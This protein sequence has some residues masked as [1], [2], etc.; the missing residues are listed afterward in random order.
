MKPTTIF[1]ASAML[2]FSAGAPVS[3][4]G[5]DSTNHSSMGGMKMSAADMDKMMSCRRMSKTEMMN[6]KGCSDAMKMHP[7]MMKMTHAEM[8]K[9]SA[10]MGM[11]K[12]VMMAD[13]SCA[14]M[15]E[16]HRNSSGAM[17]RTGMMGKR[18]GGANASAPPMMGA[19]ENTALMM[20]KYPPCTR[21][22]I[23]SCTQTNERGM[24]ANG[25]RH[26]KH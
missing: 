26:T 1:L 10:C 25:A 4:Q 19:N 17:N 6:D 24:R 14:S 8:E 23:D 13:K 21:E 5:H 22:R 3:A 15:M 12:S 20:G 18:Q 16:K 11:S 9:M 7:D 2:A